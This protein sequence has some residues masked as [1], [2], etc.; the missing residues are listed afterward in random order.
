M[1]LKLRGKSLSV[2]V[3]RRLA[4]I[5]ASKRLGEYIRAGWMKR[6]QLKNVARKP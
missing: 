5:P 1:T 6:Y 4:R 2:K 3:C